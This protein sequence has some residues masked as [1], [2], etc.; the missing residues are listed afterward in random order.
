MEQH[1]SAARR[2]QH[3]HRPFVTRCGLK[4]EGGGGAGRV[5]LANPDRSYDVNHDARMRACLLVF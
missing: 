5:G 3:R 4:Q 1:W 2:L